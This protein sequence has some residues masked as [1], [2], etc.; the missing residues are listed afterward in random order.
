M[1]TIFEKEQT[2]VKWKYLYYNGQTEV[3]DFVYD[4]LEDE[5]R[6][7][8]SSVINI[9]DCPNVET[10]IKY[11]LLDEL[12]VG[13]KG[14]R[15]KHIFPM[16]SLKKFKVTKDKDGNELF[17]SDIINFFNKVKNTI[18][19]CTPKFDGNSMELIY[20]NNNGVFNLNQ[21][22]TRGNEDL[23]GGL[24]KTDKMKLIVPNTII[25][26]P[27]Y[28]SY[29]KI[30]IRGEVIIPTEI[31]SQ[32]WSDP[33]K[34]DNPRNWLAGVLNSDDINYDAVKDMH[35]VAYQ[36]TFIENGELTRPVDQLGYLG[37]YGFELIFSLT[38]SG[39]D[40]FFTNIYPK[41]VQHRIDSQYALDG[42]VLNFSTEHWDELGENNHHPFYACAV[43]FPPNSA[44]TIM[45]NI[46]WS[47]GKDGE[48]TPVA[49]FKPIELD[50]TIV[51]HASLHNLQWIIDNGVFPGCKVELVKF[52]EIIPGVKRVL[53]KSP[54]D[55]EYQEYLSNFIIDHTK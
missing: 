5:L 40:D 17:P 53:E 3:P 36:V 24:D 19:T 43:K 23:G 18:V 51:K 38:T 11:N 22:L 54:N 52:G 45:E 35:F 21:S 50:G 34:V 32:K 14:I 2:L 28:K 26:Q 10:L 44:I 48:L 33:N 30:V 46:N 29:D 55:K 8:G 12:T 13:E 6:E 20:V 31:W 9:V 4:K 37:K 25:P 16:L 39:V 15:F 47:L 41:F 1:T 49:L 27:E 7:L 42:I